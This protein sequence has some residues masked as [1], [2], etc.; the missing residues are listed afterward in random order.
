[1]GPKTIFKEAPE[2]FNV[3]YEII[4]REDG[5]WIVKAFDRNNNQLGVSISVNTPSDAWKIY[6]LLNGYHYSD[7]VQLVQEKVSA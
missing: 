4:G 1:M 5:R 2:R 7:P 3:R 6:M